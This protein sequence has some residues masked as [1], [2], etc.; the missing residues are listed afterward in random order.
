MNITLQLADLEDATEIQAMQVR[1]FAPLLAKYQDHDT[2]PAN[3]SV[4]GIERRIRQ[5]QTD[6]YRIL[7]GEEAVGAI[8]IVRGEPAH[9][10][11]PLFVL[12]EYQGRGIAQQTFKLI[13]QLYPE[14]RYWELATVREE[15]GNCHLY[16]KVGYTLKGEPEVVNERMTMVF[17][18]KVIE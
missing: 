6:Y 13:E 11:S 9:R 7:E 1:A 12:P 16:E 10:I 14:V 8:R 4:E 15:R 2:S 3:E 5:P 17:Y 18:E